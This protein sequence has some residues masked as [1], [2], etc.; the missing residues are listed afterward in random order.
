NDDAQDVFTGNMFV[1]D[2][3]GEVEAVTIEHKPK[4]RKKKATSGKT[5]SSATATSLKS[6]QSTSRASSE[7]LCFGVL[8]V[9]S[10]EAAAVKQFLEKF[11]KPDTSESE[12]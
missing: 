11:R 8:D 4:Q 9:T 5:T 1:N 12:R 7:T 3:T 2:A 6:T 10:E